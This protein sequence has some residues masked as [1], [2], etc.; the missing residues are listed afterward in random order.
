M[1][2]K[3]SRGGRESVLTKVFGLDLRSLAL[4][5]IGISLFV[6]YDLISRLFDLT[7]HYTDLG[8]MPRIFAAAYFKANSIYT[9]W[10]PAPLSLHMY[11]GST[12][13]T[14]LLFVIHAIAAIALL[15]GFRTRLMTIIVWY[16]LSSLH[17]RNPLVLSGADDLVRV[18]LFFSIFL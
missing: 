11:A 1:T 3:Q 13:G 9:A 17:T 8:T 12:W 6:L 16:L 10:D 14:T 4:F 18:F 5:R 15:L 2:T 7:A